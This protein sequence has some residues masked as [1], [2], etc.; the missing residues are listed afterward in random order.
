MHEP[1]RRGKTRREKL[2]GGFG[3]LFC[4][5]SEDSVDEWCGGCFLRALNE[6]DGFVNGGSSGDTF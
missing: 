6:L 5:F 2:L 3:A 4:R 1:L